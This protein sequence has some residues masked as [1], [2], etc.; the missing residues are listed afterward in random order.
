VRNLRVKAAF[1]SGSPARPSQR[2]FC[3]AGQWGRLSRSVRIRAG[4]P[5]TALHGPGC[6]CRGENSSRLWGATHPR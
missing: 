1:G 2:S 4:H 5:G 3:K 6:S